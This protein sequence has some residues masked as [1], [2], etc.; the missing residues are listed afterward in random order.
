M[1]FYDSV[2]SQKFSERLIYCK[3]WRQT[4]LHSHVYIKISSNAICASVLSYLQYCPIY[5]RCSQP[6]PIPNQGSEVLWKWCPVT[7]VLQKYKHSTDSFPLSL[8]FAR[9]FIASDSNS[10][11]LEK[12]FTNIPILNQH[13]TST[14]H[15]E[16]DHERLSSILLT[17]KKWY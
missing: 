11:K 1:P 6:T 12:T 10:Q 16:N 9:H 15:H 8:F 3:E 13:N 2:I 5:Y 4:A 7:I 17:V 14:V